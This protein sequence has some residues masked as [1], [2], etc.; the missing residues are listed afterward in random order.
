M[1]LEG[2]GARM[3]AM[4]LRNGVMSVYTVDDPAG[5]RVI[6]NALNR[7]QEHM[8]ALTAT[9]EAVRLCPSCRLLR[10]AVAS[11]RL[12][13][14]V[15]PVEGGAML[16]MTSPDPAVIAMLRAEAGITPAPRPRR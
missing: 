8:I 16:L 12:A 6:R 3:Q 11:G 13:R 14:E 1:E 2:A 9:G 15:T 5:M 7:Y 10:G 4:P